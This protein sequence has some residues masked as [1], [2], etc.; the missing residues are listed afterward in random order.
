MADGAKVK[1]RMDELGITGAKLAEMTETDPPRISQI[2][3]GRYSNLTER[4]LYK[5][6]DALQCSP[7]DIR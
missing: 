7:E 5:L 3:S 6:C 2:I 1:A 4:T